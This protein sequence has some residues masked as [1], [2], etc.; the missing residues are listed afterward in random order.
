MSQAPP[1]GDLHAANST[2][3]NSQ[4]GR[5]RGTDRGIPGFRCDVRIIGWRGLARLLMQRRTVRAVPGAALRQRRRAF[6]QQAVDERT[7][8]DLLEPT[9]FRFLATSSVSIH[10]H[11]EYSNPFGNYCNGNRFPSRRGKRTGSRLVP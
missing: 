9:I 7:T 10:T 6:Y 1:E 11:G 3:I 5:A 4:F 8:V 2:S